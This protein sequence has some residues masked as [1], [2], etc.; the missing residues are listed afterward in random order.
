[1]QS[2]LIVND[3]VTGLYKLDIF[4]PAYAT[5]LNEQGLVMI[6]NMLY[7]FDAQALKT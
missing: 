1:M 6:E 3:E 5:V 7:H 4:N 2:G